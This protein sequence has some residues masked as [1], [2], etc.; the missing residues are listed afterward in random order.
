M[1]AL[2]LD[3]PGGKVLLPLNQTTCIGRATVALHINDKHV[4]RAHVEVT[5]QD[6]ASAMVRALQ[7]C[8][9]EQGLASMHQQLRSGETM[10]VR[11]SMLSM[12]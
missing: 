12:D 3:D 5:V 1:Y 2:S 7:L 6:G 8:F 10:Q 9:I 4:S 11:H